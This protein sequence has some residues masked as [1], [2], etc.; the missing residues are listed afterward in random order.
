[1][2]EGCV[3]EGAREEAREEAREGAIEGHTYGPLFMVRYGLL[4]GE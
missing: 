4:T 2:S 1:M 3:R